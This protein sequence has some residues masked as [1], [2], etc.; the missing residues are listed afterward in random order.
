M[1]KAAHI[2]R[3]R[4][5]NWWDYNRAPINRGRLTVWVDER[6]I[7]AWRNTEPGSG[8]GAPQIYSDLAIDC[9]LVFRAVYRLSFRAAQGARSFP[10][11]PSPTFPTTTRPV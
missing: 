11:A 10:F 1:P 9:A 3:Y 7:R 6:A 8:P 2:F 5:R 4:I